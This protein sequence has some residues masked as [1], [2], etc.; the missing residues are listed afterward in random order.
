MPSQVAYWQPQSSH[1]QSPTRKHSAATSFGRQAS[2]FG[3]QVPIFQL[4]PVNGSS[5]NQLLQFTVYP[6]TDDDGM[7]LAAFLL[8]QIS[9]IAHCPVGIPSVCSEGNF[10][11]HLDR[12][13]FVSCFHYQVCFPETA[14]VP[15]GDIYIR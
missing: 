5:I 12:L 14:P 13:R 11:R 4:M 7:G 2:L 6:D 1:W 15:G 10:C 9:G 3:L 8:R